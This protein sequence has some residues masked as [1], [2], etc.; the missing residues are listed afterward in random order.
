MAIWT[1]KTNFLIDQGI[2]ITLPKKNCFRGSQR[3]AKERIRRSIPSV[4]APDVCLAALSEG[5]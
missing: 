1:R 4:Y 3:L 5:E 2:Y